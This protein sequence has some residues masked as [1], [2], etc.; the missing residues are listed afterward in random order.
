MALE[1]SE[2]TKVVLEQSIKQSEVAMKLSEVTTTQCE[3]IMKQSDVAI[4]AKDDLIRNL[5]LQ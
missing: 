3:A 1:Q 2:V 4:E 5:S